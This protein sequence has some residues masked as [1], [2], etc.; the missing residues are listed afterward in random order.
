MPFEGCLARCSAADL[1]ALGDAARYSGR[2]SLAERAF[3]ALRRR[4]PGT[5]DG[6]VAAFLL[7]RTYEAEHRSQ[8][9]G[10]WYDH[11]LVRRLAV[12]SRSRRRPARLVP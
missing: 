8:Q 12:N 10:V 5:A 9:A 2:V 4:F 7:G 6:T 1:R 11:Y 3:L